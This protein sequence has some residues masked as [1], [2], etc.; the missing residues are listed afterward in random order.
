MPALEEN[1]RSAYFKA[2]AY[3]LRQPR[4]QTELK[5]LWI[6]TLAS[7]ELTG[8][9]GFV[10][11][12]VILRK[13]VKAIQYQEVS[14]LSELGTLRRQLEDLTSSPMLAERHSAEIL[15]RANQ[16]KKLEA[17]CEH[18]WRLW[19]RDRFLHFGDTNSPYFLRKFRAKRKRA[20][21]S[22][23]II[24]NGTRVSSTTEIIGEVHNHFKQVFSAPEDDIP[25]NLSGEFLSV[26]T[27]RLSPQHSAFM[28]DVPTHG[29]TYSLA[30]QG[31]WRAGSFPKG[32]LEGV[33]TLVPKETN[34]E[35][36]SGWRP[37]TLL[38]SLYKLYV[39][40]IAS[41]P[42]DWLILGNFSV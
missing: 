27:G 12:W 32:F 35:T 25:M 30:M 6:S 14:K 28:D 31:C 22:S 19:S 7:S 8:I 16:I 1:F 42:R 21:I 40:L 13:R 4:I 39:K 2:D 15:D 11:A 36:L 37:I 5:D 3:L 20:N 17:W 24:A 18:R 10:E 29:P 34:A 23:L 9:E 41:R 33:V 38:S 26:L